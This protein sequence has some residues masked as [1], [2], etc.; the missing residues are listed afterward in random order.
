VFPFHDDVAVAPGEIIF[1]VVL[2]KAY[3]AAEEVQVGQLVQAVTLADGILA[4]RWHE[5]L[6]ILAGH[7][8]KGEGR[9]IDDAHR[10]T[11]RGEF[12]VTGVRFLLRPQA[13][14][15]VG[16]NHQVV[17]EDFA[18]MGGD[19]K[20]ITHSLDAEIF[21]KAG[22]GRV[23]WVEPFR[24]PN[25]QVK[26]TVEDQIARNVKSREGGPVF[27]SDVKTRQLHQ[28]VDYHL[29]I[30]NAELQVESSKK[31]MNDTD[32]EGKTA[33]RSAHHKRFFQDRHPFRSLQKVGLR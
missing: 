16:M 14:G 26:F 18:W 5:F 12:A 8:I 29:P 22:R 28:T 15:S 7:G 21:S 4:L 27:V 6:D 11:D 3:Q 13:G 10:I 31:V 19:Q 17:I 33:P 24:T 23:G 1:Q 9:R 25:Q 32:E 20:K 2:E 30:R